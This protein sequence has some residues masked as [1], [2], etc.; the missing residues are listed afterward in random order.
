MKSSRKRMIVAAA[1]AVTTT[2]FQFFPS[3]CYQYGAIAGI[4]SFDFCTVLNCQNGSYFN[5][6]GTPVLLLDCPNATVTAP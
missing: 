4:A 3:S 1:L 5:L 2:V 6:C